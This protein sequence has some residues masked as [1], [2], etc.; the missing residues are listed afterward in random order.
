MGN[1]RALAAL[2][3]RQHGLATT[4]QLEA[5]GIGSAARSRF[6]R[7]G[8]LH[9]YD[10]GIYVRPNE[11]YTWPQSVM[12]ATLLGGRRALA[13]HRTAAVL[14]GVGG[15]EPETPEI[16]IPRGRSN[17]RSWFTAH[18]SNDLDLASVTRVAG[19]PTT[20][21]VRLAVDLGCHVGPHRYESVVNEL[22][23]TYAVTN[24][25]LLV[26]YLQHSERGRTGCGP[27]HDWLERFG[28][29]S[30]WSDSALEEKALDILLGL[31]FPAPTRQFAVDL[32]FT[33]VFLDLA[34]PRHRVDV[35][36]DG[37]HH[38][39]GRQ[40]SWDH[41]RTAELERRGWQVLRIRAWRWHHDLQRAIVELRSIL[42][43]AK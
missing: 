40:R 18:E 5:L 43:E 21:P 42:S 13:S 10:R 28:S 30:G 26:A 41:R 36:V 7:C 22:K 17:R 14:L 23:K 29:V 2:F 39:Q 15:L 38:R 20:G 27:L 24:R 4:K 11:P 37:P 31:G 34:Y 25:D 9:A 35:E 3:D 16:T 33:T 19:I 32:G 8:R 1:H 6:V 12:A